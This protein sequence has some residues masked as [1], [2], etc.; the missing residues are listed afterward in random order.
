MLPLFLLFFCSY[1]YVAP[2][3]VQDFKESLLLKVLP[4]GNILAHFE[5][6]TIWN[7]TTPSDLT[8]SSTGQYYYD[9]LFKTLL[10]RHY[11][12]FPRPVAEVVSL[13]KVNELHLSLTRGKWRESLW[14]YPPIDSPPG[15]ELWAW[16]LP[17]AVT[18]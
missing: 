12:M 14:G 8:Q 2:G 3:S 15:A 11:G 10:V 6:A 4:D 5:H 17:Q 9:C 18:E 7:E 16:F 1:F 13:Y